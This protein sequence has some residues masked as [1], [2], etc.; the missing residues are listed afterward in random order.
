MHRATAPR[1]GSA[2]HT[3]AASR[4][5]TRGSTRAGGS[6]STDSARRPTSSSRTRR[7]RCTC[8]R[9]AHR[10]PRSPSNKKNN[11]ARECADCRRTEVRR[12]RPHERVVV[13]REAVRERRDRGTRHVHHRRADRRDAVDLLIAAERNVVGPPRLDIDVTAIDEAFGDLPHRVRIAPRRLAARRQQVK[14]KT[15]RRKSRV[16]ACARCYAPPE[17]GFAGA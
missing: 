7:S 6:P 1:A 2:L 10:T 3:C 16:P 5:T 9:S 14:A 11:T 8:S 12:E 13:A 4:G 15:Q 17:C